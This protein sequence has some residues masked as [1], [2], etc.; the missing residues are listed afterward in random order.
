LWT[1]RPDRA[2]G[3]IALPAPRNVRVACSNLAGAGGGTG[4]YATRHPARR[5]N[6]DR[7]GTSNPRHPPL[8]RVARSP[9]Q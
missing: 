4:D 8:R 7:A 1:E 3:I 2:S 6:L 9:D 5:R